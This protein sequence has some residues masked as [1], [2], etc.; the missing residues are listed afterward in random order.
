MQ[1]QEFD[2]M[3]HRAAPLMGLKGAAFAS[4]D[5]SRDMKAAIPRA[6]SIAQSTIGVD[7]WKCGA[8]S[9]TASKA[10]AL[11]PPGSFAVGAPNQD[12]ERREAAYDTVRNAARALRQISIRLRIVVVDRAIEICISRSD[13]KTVFSGI[14]RPRLPA[15]DIGFIRT[16]DA[17]QIDLRLRRGRRTRQPES[18]RCYRRY[19]LHLQSSWHPVWRRMSEGALRLKLVFKTGASK[20]PVF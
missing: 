2:K 4:C 11:S 5:R 18:D 9:Q 10:F 17:K 14:R 15:R 1:G 20:R 6:R 7:R 3:R 13:A 19:P 12:H 8:S 16:S